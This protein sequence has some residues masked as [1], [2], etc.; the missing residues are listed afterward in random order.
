[1]SAYDL[2]SETRPENRR[3]AS[4]RTPGMTSQADEMRSLY[5]QTIT[6]LS[7]T[8]R[9]L[10]RQV[11]KPQ[12]VP[13]RDGFVFRFIEQTLEQA[14]LL[15]LA[16]VVTGL[17]AV[18]VLLKAGLLQEMAATCR[19]LD[20]I[21]EDI[22]FLAAPLTND[23]ITELHKRY[24]GG[25]WAEEFQAP[26]NTLARH[27]K[28]DTPKRNKIQAYV[29]RVLNP[30][31]NPSRIADVNQAL[32]STYSGYIHASAPQVMDLYGGNPAHFHIEGMQ[33]TPL[34]E[35]HVYDAWNYFYRGI[36]GG[37]V[38]SRAFGD[39]SLSKT[40]GEFHDKFLEQSG[41]RANGLPRIAGAEPQLRQPA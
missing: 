36:G 9:R 7:N 33:G 27:Q 18:D 32:S 41:E 26:D 28:P 40:L 22:A 12:Q 31:D 35:D 2:F 20:E 4:G 6:V 10:E 19:M 17:R 16:R 11:P 34:M 15:K 13:F 30:D 8:F 1:M 23:E 21:G 3:S 25:F 24:L 5:L 29:Q 38:V 37:I 14:L 39:S